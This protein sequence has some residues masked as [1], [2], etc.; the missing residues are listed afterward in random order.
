MTKNHFSIERNGNCIDYVA[1]KD[2]DGTTVFD[3]VM[4]MSYNDIKSYDS[5]E[6]FIVCIMDASNKYFGNND[7]QTIV[8]LIGEDDVFIWSIIIGPDGDDQMR[9]TFVDWTKDSKKYRYEK[10]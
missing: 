2:K 9:Y 1:V 6:Q 7:D 3:D 10:N 8:T 4:N 5:I